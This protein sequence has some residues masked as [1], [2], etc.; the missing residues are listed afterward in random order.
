MKKAS[1]LFRT[2]L[3]IAILLAC[4][5][6]CVTASANDWV[7]SL[8]VTCE[9]TSTGY[10]ITSRYRSG[11]QGGSEYQMHY[12]TL[13]W[14]NGRSKTEQRNTQLGHFSVVT[15]TLPLDTPVGTYTIRARDF[16]PD[17]GYEQYSSYLTRTVRISRDSEP[18]TTT[19]PS[20]SDT[21]YHQRRTALRD[22]NIQLGENAIGCTLQVV[23]KSTLFAD[24][25]AN[26]FA[27]ASIPADTQMEILDYHF[28]SAYSA[29]FKVE[30]EQQTGWVTV[31]NV[32]VDLSS[33]DPALAVT[34][35]AD[36]AYAAAE[37]DQPYTVE[38]ELSYPERSPLN[39]PCLGSLT[40]THDAAMV[41]ENSNTASPMV[42]RVFTG[43]VYPYYEIKTYNVTRPWYYIYV[44]GVWGWISSGMCTL[45]E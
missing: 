37:N 33:R 43:E 44:D 9:E 16:S 3:S 30:Y 42:A 40:V 7:Q 36:D 28:N 31:S 12:H 6:S 18:V 23:F 41:R 45:N 8:E 34:A 21:A 5:F 29:F 22:A 25:D 10:V 38:D 15:F 20:D 2:I 27:L 11:V 1:N 19:P 39:T 24:P 17:F 13:V 26:A 32:S 4:A 35:D 14:P